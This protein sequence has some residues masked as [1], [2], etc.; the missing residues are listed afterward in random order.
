MTRA[1]KV[2]WLS[3]R[4]EKIHGVKFRRQFSI[5]NFILDFYS[6]A[7]RLAIEVDGASH[8]LPGAAEDDAVRQSWIENNFG[9]M[10][11][12]FSD[13]DV[14]SSGEDVVRKI[15]EQVRVMLP[16]ATPT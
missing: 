8:D 6:P 11:M 16:P 15:S 1:E 7:L 13:L 2:L 3:I 10:F 4:N 5:G 9:V 12:R 14:L